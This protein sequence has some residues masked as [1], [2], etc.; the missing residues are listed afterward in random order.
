MGT[1]PL[2]GV[3]TAANEVALVSQLVESMRR[4]QYVSAISARPISPLRADPAS[5]LFDPLKAAI[6][7]KRH[8]NTEE[9]FWLVFLFVLFGKHRVT[10]WRLARDVYGGL[11]QGYIWDWG[12]TSANPGDLRHWIAA[13]EAVLRGADGIQR[14]FGNHR[15]FETLKE[16]SQRGTGRVIES[17]VKCVRKLGSHKMVI[18][19]ALAGTGGDPRKAFQHLYGSMNDVISFGRTSKFDYLTMLGKLGLANIEAPSTYMNE[20]TGPLK[21][22]RLLFGGSKEANISANQLDQYV[23]DLEGALSVGCQGMQVLEDAL[24]NW[25]KS[26]DTFK[27]FRG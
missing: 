2:P 7:H 11:G 15:K 27:A 3:A 9:A 20:A 25:Q 23:I 8:G 18:E 4:V 5:D 6:F 21:G 12:R 13:N 14:A 17:Y 24:C 1:R 16:S 22:A 10:G 26:P 19:N